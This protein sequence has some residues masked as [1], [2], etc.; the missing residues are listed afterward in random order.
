MCIHCLIQQYFH[1]YQNEK[2]QLHQR[3]GFQGHASGLGL[4]VDDGY[5][6][7]HDVSLNECAQLTTAQPEMQ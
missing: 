2:Y 1:D 3:G 6:H 4:H 7:G 5:H